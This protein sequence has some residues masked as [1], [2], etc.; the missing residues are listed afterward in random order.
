[1]PLFL[2]LTFLFLHTALVGAAH[3]IETGPG[4]DDQSPTILVLVALHYLDYPL[5]LVLEKP[6][7]ALVAA[8]GGALW[9]AV[10]LILQLG[11]C[12]IGD[13]PGRTSRDAPP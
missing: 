6:T 8:A 2:P 4:W 3:F 13:R 9:F 1:M 12:S 7:W 11:L 10:G 5:Q